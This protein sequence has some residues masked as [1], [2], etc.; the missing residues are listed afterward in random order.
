MKI[1]ITGGA[2]FMGSNFI[3]YLLRT[4]PDYQVINFDKLTYAGNLENLRDLEKNPRY[5]FVQGD[6]ADASAV[7]RVMT[8]HK[9]DA[10]LNYAAET[11]V[12]RSILDPDAFIRT[13]IL[14]T[15]VLLEAVRRHQI[16]RYVQISTD[17]VY[18]EVL[19][20]RSTETAP[21]VPRSPYSASKAGADHLV[22][23]YHVTYGLPTLLT[24]SCNFIGPYQFPEKMIPFFITNLI[25]G[26]PL[27]V[28]G[29]GKQSREYIFV[30]DH[31]AAIDLVMHKGVVGETYNIGT[32]DEHV[33][34]EVTQF[35][36]DAFGAGPEMIKHVA[37]RPGHDRRYALDTKKIRQT[38][39]WAPKVSFQEGLKFTID[40]YRNH[41][42]WWRPLKSGEHLA[43][44]QKQYRQR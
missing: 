11:H 23:A 37:D 3:R 34:L 18:G 36:L 4:Y 1:L 42:A 2:G 32:E 31:C 20:G 39:G 16:Q 28:Y 8:K 40:W 35:V 13:E 10:I 41:E 33:N 14:G 12:D 38:L 25:E 29:D 7:E 6:I 27:P 24:R 9:P 19:T 15:Y 21:L 17:E 5:T 43:Y 30:D 22:Q 44:F 26:K